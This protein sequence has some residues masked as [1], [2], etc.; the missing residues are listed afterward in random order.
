VPRTL[1]NLRALLAPGGWLIA[2][3]MTRDH[4]QILTSLELLNTAAEATARYEDARASAGETFYPRETWLRLFESSGAHAAPALPPADDPFSEVGLC[5]F[6]ARY[7]TDRA[8]LAREDLDRF[9]GAR[10]PDYMVPADIVLVDAMPLTA[11]GKI[12]RKQLAAWAA[13]E[14]A[15]PEAAPVDGTLEGR[16]AAVWRE[17]LNRADSGRDV[18]FFASGGDS[19]LA[20]QLAA[21][22]LEDVPEAAGIFFDDLL[23]RVLEG[24]TLAE[25]AAVISAGAATTVA[26]AETPPATVLALDAS[27]DRPLCLLAH[28]GGAHA[29]QLKAALASRFH[30]VEIPVDP[31]DAGRAIA[32]AQSGAWLRGGAAIRLVGCGAGNRVA[33]ELGRQLL[34]AGHD[35]VHVTVTAFGGP[36]EASVGASLLYPGDL[37]L[38]R[39]GDR[40]AAEAHWHAVCLGDVRVVTLD[41]S[42]PQD[43]A[44]TILQACGA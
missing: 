6:A 20:A 33:L 37:T 24:P 11:N 14:P 32:T 27:T 17:V 30:V 21:R 22:L 3:E 5:V 28:D 19:L 40:A 36:R 9:A 31:V 13:C 2:A 15:A 38:L 25:L 43:A 35:D 1:E 4:A 41:L 8:S 16:V 18:D 34:E 26:A 29:A 12:D 23:R 10:L 44:P 42:A 7:K 39:H